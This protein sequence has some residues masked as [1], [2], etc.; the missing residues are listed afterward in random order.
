[1]RDLICVQTLVNS[2]LLLVFA[3]R[4]D[5]K[6]YIGLTTRPSKGLTLELRLAKFLV[7]V[8]IVQ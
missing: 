8:F 7:C 6:Q 2:D 3:S 1:M 5:S 4:I